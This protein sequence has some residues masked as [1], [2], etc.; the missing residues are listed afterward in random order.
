MDSSHLILAVLLVCVIGSLIALCVVV[1]KQCGS[2]SKMAG[3][4]FRTKAAPTSP[5]TSLVGTTCWGLEPTPPQPNQ[6][7][8]VK[9]VLTTD[10]TGNV[11]GGCL[12]HTDPTQP[13]N[14]GIVTSQGTGAL[15]S[16][17]STLKIVNNSA[18]GD[19]NSPPFGQLTYD[20]HGHIYSTS[21]MLLY[22][23]ASSSCS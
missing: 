10:A 6:G 7:E 13:Y 11:N 19:Q 14:Y 3:A 17:P 5:F 20:G 2:G 8:G 12:S 4:R 9:L 23:W 1:H 15:C 16:G 18:I 22:Q 21:G